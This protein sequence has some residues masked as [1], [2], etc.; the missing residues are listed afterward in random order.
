VGIVV[1]QDATDSTLRVA[2][3]NT[4]S[5]RLLGERL[6][7]GLERREAA[8]RAL[9]SV[10]EA[11]RLDVLAL[12]EATVVFDPVSQR[13]QRVGTDVYVVGIL[14]EGAVATAFPQGGGLEVKTPI[15]SK[16]P[17]EESSSVRL[18]QAT[19]VDKLASRIVI[20]WQGQPVAIYSVHLRSYNASGRAAP[21]VWW[22]PSSWL[23]RLRTY[24]HDITARKQ[25]QSL[26]LSEGI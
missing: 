16:I 23:N 1:K 4:G 3:F 15:L 18:L 9:A 2:S 8:Y 25:R 12:Q 13:V 10:V 5:M 19:P 20:H 14:Q 22:D 21:L 24:K 7:S 26:S 17:I 6:A 11:H